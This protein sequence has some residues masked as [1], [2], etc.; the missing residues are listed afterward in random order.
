MEVRKLGGSGPEISHIVFGCGA[1][2][3]VIFN[4]KMDESVEAVRRALDHGIN[5]FDTAASYGDGRSEERLGK[6][7]K[8]LGARPRV[9]T[10]VV[11]A[12]AEL[13]DI[14]GSIRRSLERSLKRLG[15]ERVDLFQ[16]HNSVTPKRGGWRNSISLQDVLGPGGVAETF[17]RLREEGLFSL[18]GYT[19]NGDAASLIT[20]AESGRFQS[21]QAYFNLLN[22]TAVLEPPP[23]FKGHN[24]KQLAAKAHE[25]GLG[26]LNIRVL[27]AGVLAGKQLPDRPGI[28]DG[29]EG[30]AENARAQ[31]LMEELEI[32]AKG[33]YRLALRFAF[34]QE[35]IDGVLIGFSA[36]DHV[37]AAVA[38]LAEP[39][40][41]PP[42]LDRIRR[43]Y[44]KPPFSS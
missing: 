43:L 6:I 15:M 3:G 41:E 16:L 7:L 25:K 34:M 40:V 12:P 27:A 2:G 14:P 5:W 11:L 38:A 32:D 22:P 17:E 4:A 1:V 42:L 24:F 26:V 18:T 36:P 35:A 31:T 9:S 20:M 8:E 28:V 19:G 10:K 23:G 33:L 21:V 39:S 13:K 30:A 29:A 44:R 37:D